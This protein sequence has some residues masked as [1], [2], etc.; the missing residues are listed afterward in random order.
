MLDRVRTAYI[1]GGE[2]MLGTQVLDAPNLQ[3]GINKFGHSDAMT[4]DKR[5]LLLYEL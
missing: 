5:I 2:Y 3:A 1:N 4:I